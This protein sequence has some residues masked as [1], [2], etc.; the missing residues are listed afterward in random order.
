[1]RALL[2]EGGKTK[3]LAALID[4]EGNVLGFSIGGSTGWTAVGF[5]KALNTLTETV[6]NVLTKSGLK[7]EV[8]VGVFGLPDLDTEKA[9]RLIENSLNQRISWIKEKVIVPD[10]VVAY[11]AVT[12]GAPGVAVIAGTGSIAYGKNSR[13]E[14]ARAGG[15]GWFGDD[16]GSALWIAMKAVAA[17]GKAWDGRG[18]GTIL[19]EKI[20]KHFGLTN[21][22]DL[23]DVLY[24]SA[25]NDLSELAQI[26]KLTDEAA[27]EGDEIATSILI[28]GGRELALMAK[29]VYDKILTEENKVIVGGV[30]SVFS[31]KA[32]KESF[33]KCIKEQ[34][35][36]ALVTEPL[37][38]Y[39]PIRGLAAILSEKWNIPSS[40]VDKVTNY[41]SSLKND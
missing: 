35:P 32:L 13:G 4:E 5:E 7:K 6:A 1:M 37:V 24:S 38:R 34:L 41:F 30:G 19:T 20:L 33:L 26:A 12:L 25:I 23:I 21:P 31:S 22:L 39:A 2:V 28:Q 17:A 18:P 8:D 11:Y 10:F 27:R 3:T 16:E 40:F 14:A 36:E 9:S 29:A 15:W